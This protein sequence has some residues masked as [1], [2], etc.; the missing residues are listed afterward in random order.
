[1]VW[2]GTGGGG[3]GVGRLGVLGITYL[4]WLLLTEGLIPEITQILKC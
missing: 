1:M 4:K 3:G 2:S